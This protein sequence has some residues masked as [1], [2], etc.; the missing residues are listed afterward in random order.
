MLLIKYLI[1]RRKFFISIA[2]FLTIVVG[3]LFALVGGTALSPLVY[4]LF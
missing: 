1:K 3:G 4:T 2:I